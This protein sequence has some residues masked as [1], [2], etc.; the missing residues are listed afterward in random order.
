MRRQRLVLTWVW[1]YPDV[2]YSGNYNISMDLCSWITIKA[3]VGKYKSIIW[4]YLIRKRHKIPEISPGMGCSLLSHNASISA[5]PGETPS[6][7][8]GL[9]SGFSVRTNEWLLNCVPVSEPSF[10]RLFICSTHL[11]K[12]MFLSNALANCQLFW[13]IVNMCFW[14]GYHGH[15]KLQSWLSLKSGVP[16]FNSWWMLHSDLTF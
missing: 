8:A 4:I 1:S 3:I 12:L 13:L 7:T 11:R 14:F 5:T 9:G 2:T 10:C 6:T 15:R 16:F